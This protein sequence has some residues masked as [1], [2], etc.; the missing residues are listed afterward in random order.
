MRAFHDARG[1][2]TTIYLTPVDDPRAY[3]L[4]ETDVDG[5]LVRFREKPGPHEAITTNLINAGVYLLDA[6]LLERLPKGE[7]RSIERDFFPAVI[8]DGI[9][10]FGW[11]RAAYW[12][13]IGSPAAYLGAQID[14]LRGDVRTPLAPDG[15]VRDGVWI[16]RA[17]TCEPGAVIEAPCVIG[18]GARVSAGSRVG[19]FAVLGDGA[20]VARA[21]R[22][23]HSLL[24]ERVDVG[25]GASIAGAVLGSDVTVGAAAELRAG[26][27]V[28]SNT[29]VPGGARLGPER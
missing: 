19:P 2:R 26:V 17:A 8:A 18:A 29:V 13:D 15:D 16:G 12:R 20:R 1:S 27:V 21:A 24:W 4:V 22:V 7:A 5:R 6:T 3:G 11:R 23:E 14:L 9:P 28:E 10:S 25:E